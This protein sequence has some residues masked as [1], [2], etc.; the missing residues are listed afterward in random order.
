[1]S[2]SKLYV[3]ELDGD[4]GD[5]TTIRKLVQVTWSNGGSLDVSRRDI[6]AMRRLV[7]CKECVH[8]HKSDYARGRSL[9]CDLGE[10]DIVGPDDFCSWGET[11]EDYA[12]E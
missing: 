9:V 2:D 12:D 7:C 3:I 10:G 5:A 11:E 6:T 1:M 4:G 8:A